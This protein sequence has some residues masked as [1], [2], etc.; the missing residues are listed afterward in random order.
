MHVRTTEQWLREHLAQGGASQPSPFVL[1]TDGTVYDPAPL[2]TDIDG[3]V[4]AGD[5]VA[6]EPLVLMEAADTVTAPDDAVL[7]PRS[8][9]KTDYVA[10][11]RT[12]RYLSTPGASDDTPCLCVGDVVEAE[13]DRLGRQRHGLRQV[14]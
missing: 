7:T 11:G 10:S 12:G 1:D 13:I 8:S 3:A 9:I 2:T 5:A 14:W 6:A 4:L